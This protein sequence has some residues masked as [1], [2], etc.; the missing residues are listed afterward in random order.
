MVLLGCVAPTPY[1]Q[2][3][4]VRQVR[5]PTLLLNWALISTVVVS[6]SAPASLLARADGYQVAGRGAWGKSEK[7]SAAPA[8]P[9]TPEVG[10]QERGFIW[11]WTVMGTEDESRLAQY[12]AAAA[13]ALRRCWPTVLP[14]LPV[15]GARGVGSLNPS[16]GPSA[17]TMVMVA[18]PPGSAASRSNAASRPGMGG[19]LTALTASSRFL[20]P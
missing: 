8:A 9:M 2:L 12:A 16:P 15:T 14:V 18:A 20:F 6:R 5:L 7:K 13:K 3:R 19:F 4:P 17:L 10:E 11:A 1:H